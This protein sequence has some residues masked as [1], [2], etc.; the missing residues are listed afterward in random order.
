MCE[1]IEDLTLDPIGRGMQTKFNA[2]AHGRDN[3]KVVIINRE[4]E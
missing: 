3:I 1:W 2:K 4:E